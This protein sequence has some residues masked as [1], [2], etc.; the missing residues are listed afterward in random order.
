[1]KQLDLPMPKGVAAPSAKKGGKPPGKS[2][3]PKKKQPLW[4]NLV[5]MLCIAVFIGGFGVF[6]YP[7]FSDQWNNYRQSLLISEYDDVIEKTMKPEDFDAIW[8]DAYDYQESIKTNAPYNDM[9]AQMDESGADSQAAIA[10][11]EYGRILNPAGNGSMGYLTIPKIDVKLTIYHGTA[12]DVLHTGVG[13]MM[14][15]S[16]PIGGISTHAVLS[17]HRGLPSAKL[18]TDI[19][20]LRAGDMAY[21]KILDQTFAYEIDAVRDMIDKNDREALTEAM[22]IIDGEDRLTL[23]TC[24]P[25][26][27]NSHR[28]L[29][30]GHRVPYAPGDEPMAES[31]GAPDGIVESVKSYYMIYTVMGLAI[32]GSLS[33]AIYI[34]IRLAGR[35]GRKK[36]ARPK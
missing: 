2:S 24:T 27:V 11:T 29:V 25:Y 35:R 17:A 23:F 19:D 6:A 21:I 33:L 9:F 28:L 26:G 31:A 3:R 30:Q 7:T 34:I 13:H 20:Q 22:R 15:T 10:A 1:M 18:F 12:E 14:G 16:L 8:L 32:G 36:E 4:V 5:T